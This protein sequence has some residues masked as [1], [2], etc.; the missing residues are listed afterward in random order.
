MKKEPKIRGS[1]IRFARSLSN[2]FQ[3]LLRMANQTP[4]PEI[5][6]KS[7]MRQILIRPIASQILS[8]GCALWM[9]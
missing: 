7:G 5:M 6:N 1:R 8:T 9:K 3:F 4:I 2:S